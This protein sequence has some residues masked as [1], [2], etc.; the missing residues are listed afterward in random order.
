[1]ILYCKILSN[2]AEDIDNME[3]YKSLG[4]DNMPEMEDFWVDRYIEIHDAQF[5]FSY[6]DPKKDFSGNLAIMFAGIQD[7]C[8]VTNIPFS[9]FEDYIPSKRKDIMMSYVNG[10]LMVSP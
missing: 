2:R 10:K 4:L 9:E 8:I 7:V 6:D 1:M 3:M 5:L